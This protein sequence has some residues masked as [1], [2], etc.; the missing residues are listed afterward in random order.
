M[1][2]TKYI[3]WMLSQWGK[4]DTVNLTQPSF[5][6]HSHLKVYHKTN[7]SGF[8]THIKLWQKNIEKETHQIKT[9]MQT[10]LN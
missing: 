4:G 2:A 3:Y 8:A 7:F 5:I 9:S 10:T 1:G 6:F